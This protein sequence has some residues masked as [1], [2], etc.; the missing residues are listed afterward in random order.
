[1]GRSAKG[2]RETHVTV[3][4]ESPK[5]VS[6][7][8]AYFA[9][10]GLSSDGIPSLPDAGGVPTESTAVVLFP[11]EVAVTHFVASLRSL[12]AARPRLL[13]LV[14]TAAPQRFRDALEPDGHSLPP[15]VL[16][17]PV[18]GWTILDAVRA[19]ALSHPT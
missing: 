2:R 8:R 16:P 13:V 14:V 17:K 19:H 4:S 5:T 1:M 7:L 18:F 11:D 6:D 12:R 15:V 3:V 9:R 10:A